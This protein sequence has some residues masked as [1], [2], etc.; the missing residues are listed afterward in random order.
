MLSAVGNFHK[1][2]SKLIGVCGCYVIGESLGSSVKRMIL[3]F[4]NLGLVER[5]RAFG[6][7][8]RIRWGCGRGA[9]GEWSCVVF[10]CAF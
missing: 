8:I 7:S 2:L 9:W 5:G 6:R 4:V 1:F 10:R 3:D